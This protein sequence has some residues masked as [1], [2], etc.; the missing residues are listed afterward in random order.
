M[1]FRLTYEGHLLGASRS[2]TRASHK[3]EIRK[4]FHRQL[5]HYWQVHPYLSTAYLSHR[6]LGRVQPEVK[7]VDHLSQK[8]K[9]ENYNFV[10][11]VTPDL[12][13]ICSLEI[14]FLRRGFPGEAVRSGDID[15]R[16]K[17]I[18]DA[19][20]MP[21]NSSELG[22]FETPGDDEIPFF[23]LLTDDN[24]ISH[25]SV[26]TDTLLEPSSAEAG[27]NDSRLVIAVKLKP[28]DVGW[29]NISFG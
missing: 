4:I 11:L 5:R 22:G 12:S 19:L 16:L 21:G 2:N 25:V 26:E 3:H 14:L 17:T 18:F 13:L 27:D 10:P 28:F 15:N 7:L 8:Y 23:C 9:L 20:R 6:R 24:L 1:E 29:D